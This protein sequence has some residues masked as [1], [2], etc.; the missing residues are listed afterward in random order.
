MF[1]RR[2]GLIALLTV[3]AACGPIPQPFK[4]GP[5]AKDTNSLLSIPDGAG[6]TVAPVHGAGAELSGPL[7]E[8]LVAALHDQEIPATAGGS[9]TNGLLME[10]VADWVDG[11]AF[12][13]WILTDS[14]SEVVATVTARA[15][16]DRARF[17]TGDPA[18]V[19]DLAQR[20]AVLIA[21][22]MKPENT[23]STARQ[24]V[25]TV[26]VVGV[27]GAPGDG[28]QALSKAMSAVLGEAGVPMAETPDSAALLLAGGVSVE[29]LN[30]ELEEVVIQWWLMD[31]TGAVLGTLEQANVIPLGA[32]NERWGGAAYDAALANVEAI[33]EILS[34]I[35]EIREMQRQANEQLNR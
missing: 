34:R 28:D 23:N 26:A 25:P 29:K 15:A 27:E 8:A 4:E 35:D 9:L 1:S 18:L 33:R 10:G 20:G 24:G 12:V 17:D 3:L 5:G 21:A 22:A 6:V 32:L 13:V 30:D 2:L 7:T 11:E 31:E 14:Q 16:A 19:S